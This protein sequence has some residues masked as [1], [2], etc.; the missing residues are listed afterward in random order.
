MDLA[1]RGMHQDNPALP[2]SKLNRLIAGIE[3]WRGTDK[4]V[5]P[6]SGNGFEGN[7]KAGAH[8]VLR[9]I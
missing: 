6:R 9:W 5:A 8:E 4:A 1:F 2:A 7:L 3:N